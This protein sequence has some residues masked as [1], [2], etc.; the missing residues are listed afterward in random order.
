ML[1]YIIYH[2]I[3]LYYCIVLYHVIVYCIAR[4]R[5]GALRGRGLAALGVEGAAGG[6]GQEPY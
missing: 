3:V 6:P 2:Y 4:V 1:G 5:P